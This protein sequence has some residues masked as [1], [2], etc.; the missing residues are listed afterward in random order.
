MSPELPNW[1]YE[2]VALNV[3][4]HCGLVS[5]DLAETEHD[6]FVQAVRQHHLAQGAALS[7]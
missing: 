7:G 5:G 4:Q 2:L 6:A 1:F 3:S